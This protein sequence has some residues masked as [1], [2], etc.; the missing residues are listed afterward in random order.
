MSI[1]QYA[2]DVKCDK[3]GEVTEVHVPFFMDLEQRLA[4]LGWIIESPFEDTTVYV[5]PNCGGL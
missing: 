3:C 5:C 2:T 4:E 1:I